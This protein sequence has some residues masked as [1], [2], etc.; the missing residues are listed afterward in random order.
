[1][2]FPKFERLGLAVLL[3]EVIIDGSIRGVLGINISR[4]FAPLHGYHFF[5]TM[6]RLS[7]VKSTMVQRYVVTYDL[8]TGSSHLSMIC[9]LYCPE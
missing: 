3:V 8:V 9:I 6:L 7:I 1:M 4:F 2:R 5:K